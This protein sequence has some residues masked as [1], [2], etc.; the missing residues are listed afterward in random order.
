[1]VME[2]II[3]VKNISFNYDEQTKIFDQ[4][5]LDIYKGEWVSIIGQNGS[6]KSTLAYLIDGLLELDAGEIIVDGLEV[7]ES[8]IDNIRNQIGIVFQNPE[9]QFVG[10]TVEDDVA[11][12]LENRQTD[13]EKMQRIVKDSL[14]NVKMWHFKDKV[15][16]NLSGGQKQRVAIAGIIAVSPQ[17]IILD[18]AT[19]ML[20]PKGRQDI[21]RLIY[22]LKQERDLTVISITHDINE[23]AISD[24]III[25]NNGVVLKEDTPENIFNDSAELIKV[26]LDVPFTVQLSNKLK[27]LGLNVPDKYLDEGDLIEWIK[28]YHLSK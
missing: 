27:Q 28:Q 6:G 1:M 11:F 4:F 18:E 21:L 12:G 23:A 5:S 10:A 17:I 14:E 24:R 25:L 19:S 2:K 7:N 16:S 9:D 15:P 22:K 26:G 13:R 20:D 3:Q 8:N